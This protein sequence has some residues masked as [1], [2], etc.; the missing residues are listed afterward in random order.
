MA[1]PYKVSPEWNEV[2]LPEAVRSA[3]STKAGVWGLLRTLEGEAL[4]VFHE[5]NERSTV[6]TPD[7]PGLIEPQA[8]HHVELSGPVRLC[9]E[10]YRERPGSA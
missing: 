9:V 10:F 6:V 7:R 8:V 3:H 2:T 4:L 1:D 5:P